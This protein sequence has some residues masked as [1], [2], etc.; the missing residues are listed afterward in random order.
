MGSTV[1]GRDRMTTRTVVISGGGSG[2]GAGVAARFAE[3][4]DRVFLLDLSGERAAATAAAIGSPRVAARQVDVTDADA[5][6]AA[7]AGIHADTGAID[8]LVSNAGVFDACAT[9]RT[10]THELWRRVIDI[11][12]TGAFNLIKP[13]AEVMIAQGSGRIIGIGSV[14]GQRAMPDGLAYCTSKAA[15]EGMFRRLAYDLGPHGITAN[16][17]APG[18][19]RSAI[20][21][22]S[23]E[24]L[25]A[26][27]PDTAVGVGTDPELM[28]LLIPVKRAGQP[29]DI[30]EVVLF[31]ASDGAGYITGDVIHVDGG[32]IAA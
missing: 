18:V 25:G 12:L 13:V 3:V 27:V 14:A 26:S 32:W 20:R 16:I 8:V 19:I 23:T 1:D 24:I 5:V 17:V 31:L 30:A 4:G 9:V 15:L 21:A 7:V 11:N 22:N 29:S 28:D 2:I 10:T 6:T